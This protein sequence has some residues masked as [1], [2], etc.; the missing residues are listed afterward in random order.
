VLCAP[1]GGYRQPRPKWPIPA[2]RKKTR[3]NNQKGKEITWKFF[4]I[5][6]SLSL[7][8]LLLLLMLAYKMFYSFATTLSPA[9]NRRIKRNLYPRI[10][11]HAPNR[12]SKRTGGRDCYVTII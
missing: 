10:S 9:T 8:L 12:M 4:S 6:F 5:F 11:P 3:K 2:I 7:L 1:F